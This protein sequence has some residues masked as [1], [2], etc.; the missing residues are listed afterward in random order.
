MAPG[1]KSD[2]ELWQALA[3]LDDDLL[4][5]DLPEEILDE[6]L[7]ALGVD[8]GALAERVS[9]FVAAARNEERLSWQ[10]R[11]RER[12][13]ELDAALS[14]ARG[15]VPASMNR[16]DVLTRLGELRAT[17]PNVGTAIQMAA[18]KRKPEESTD[19]ELRTLLQEMEALRA[20]EGK[21]SD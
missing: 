2:K 1:S 6:E 15:A 10:D 7:R 3:D 20:M 13:A 19:A 5:R 4:E 18:R 8:P 9:S 11:A 16:T 17:D 12:L 14:N 21:K